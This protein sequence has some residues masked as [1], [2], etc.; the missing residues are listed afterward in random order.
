MEFFKPKLLCGGFPSST[1]RKKDEKEEET[2]L[3]IV[4]TSCWLIV[5]VPKVFKSSWHFWNVW[6]ERNFRIKIIG[7]RAGVHSGSSRLKLP[8]WLLVP[9]V[10]TTSFAQDQD[11]LWF[12]RTVLVGLVA[13]CR[14]YCLPKIVATTLKCIRSFYEAFL[15]L[16]NVEDQLVKQDSKLIVVCS[17]TTILSLCNTNVHKLFKAK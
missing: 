11:N 3:R 6:P 7:S 2:C 17:V 14:C 8:S 13:L 10:Y 16:C 4:D 15:S 12:L 5:K 1:W 9:V